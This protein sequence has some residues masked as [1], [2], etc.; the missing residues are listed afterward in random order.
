MYRYN[1]RDWAY[2][3]PASDSRYD[4]KMQNDADPQINPTMQDHDNI[5]LRQLYY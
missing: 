5:S 2:L 4:W 3:S 1:F